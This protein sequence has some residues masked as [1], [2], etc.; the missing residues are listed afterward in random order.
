MTPTLAE[1]TRQLLITYN[2]FPRK[3]LGQHFLVD[4]QV[5]A[6]I[7]AAAE[8]GPD[9]LV[10]EIGSG[11]GVVTAEL[12][13]NVHHLI[14]VEIDQELIGISKKVLESLAN[15]SFVNQD[16]LKTSLAE[17]ALGRRYKVVGNLPYYITSPII[18]KILEAEEKPEV[19]VV[20]TQKEVAER[21]VAG[22]GTKNYGS[23][24]IFCQFYAEVKL[25]SLVS[26]SSFL[27]WPEV[28][29]AVVALRPY[30]TPKYE[31]KDTKLFF[32]LVHAAFQ[33]RRKKL[34]NS[35]K[36]FGL[37]NSPVDLNR[38]PETVSIEEFASIANSL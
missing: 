4:P 32:D 10:V 9:D 34:S 7:I 11:L 3:R 16:V 6:R 27:P 25:N 22:A 19:A 18:E 38:R 35:L 33:Q 13:K 36:P 21:M 8:L 15:I 2:R 28:S 1:V 26:K 20:M 17:L 14:A 24:S 12:A 37:T 30:K 23:F 5:I 29:S 31:V